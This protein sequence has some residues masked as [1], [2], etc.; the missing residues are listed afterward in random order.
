M[1]QIEFLQFAAR[2]L[3]SQQIPWML[4]GSFATSAWGEARFTQDIDIVIDLQPDQVRPL[5]AAFSG[6]EFYVSESAARDALR[7][8]KQFNVIHPESGNKIV[9]MIPRRD[10]WGQNQI[11]RRQSDEIQPG[12]KVWISSPE[13]VI[14]SKMRYYKEGGSDKHLRDSAGVLVVQGDRIDRDYIEHWAERFALMDIWNAI[15]KRVNEVYGK[16][17]Q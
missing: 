17:Q 4:V 12:V 2:A 11:R 6:D 8:R 3:D 13:D 5:C 14:I 7:T 1:E 9:F 16:P 15:L 10:E